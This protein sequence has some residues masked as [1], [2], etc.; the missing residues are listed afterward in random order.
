MKPHVLA[1]FAAVPFVVAVMLFGVTYAQSA[2]P[3]AMDQLLVEVQR[4]RADLQQASAASM[5]MQVLVARLSLQ[6]QR[7]AAL[8][9]QSADVQQQLSAAARDKN[10]AGD[11]LNRMTS[12]VQ[13]GQI[14][15]EDQRYLEQE[16]A[17]LKNRLLEQ[18]LRESSLQ[19]RLNEIA[20]TIL[21]EQ[22]RWTE[23]NTR[24]DELERMLPALSPR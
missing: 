9:R 4:L 10:A 19:N 2:R 15:A 13:G 20:T 14:P 16:V 21:A 22:S 5:R 1:R 6:E 24:L 18:T 8:D 3:D 12:A 11:H 23:F 7:I 17:S